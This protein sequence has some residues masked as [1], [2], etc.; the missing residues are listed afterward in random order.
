M[1]VWHKALPCI[2]AVSLIFKVIKFY[3]LTKF[4]IARY[5]E[6]QLLGAEYSEEEVVVRSSDLDRTLMSASAALAGK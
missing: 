5:G 4:L 6:G 2:D 3:I 1:S